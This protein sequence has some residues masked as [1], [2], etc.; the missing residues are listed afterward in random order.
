MWN[1]ED[2]SDMVIIFRVLDLTILTSCLVL[3]AWWRSLG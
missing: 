1:F 2:E 3:V